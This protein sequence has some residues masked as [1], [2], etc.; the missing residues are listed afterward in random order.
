MLDS[1]AVLL[2]RV[3]HSG[4][5]AAG[6]TYQGTL[7][8]ALPGVLPGNYSVIVETDSQG[9]V[10]DFNRTNNVQVS[11]GTIPITVTALLVG[12][13]VSGSI[14]SGQEQ[15]FQ[16]NVPSGQDVVLTA[17]YAT[18][19]EAEL[20][21]RLGNLPSLA[22]FDQTVSNL[23]NLQPQLILSGNPGGT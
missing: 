14:S 1:S 6:G 5:V 3:K 16:V 8:A 18:T 4:A 2:G 20:E 9:V 11:S 22:T 12:N 23:T 7:T 21:T 15:Y 13:N 10:P 17:H 19:N